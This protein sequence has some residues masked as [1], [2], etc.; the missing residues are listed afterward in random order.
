MGTS[1]NQRGSTTCAGKTEQIETYQLSPAQ[2]LCYTFDS[3]CV[4]NWDAAH[5]AYTGNQNQGIFT[6]QEKSCKKW[7]KKGV[8][9]GNIKKNGKA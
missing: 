8:K 2:N 3:H 5:V 1:S 9:R 6:L 4:R 7:R